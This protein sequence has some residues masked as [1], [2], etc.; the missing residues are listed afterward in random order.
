MLARD[1]W[2]NKFP[3]DKVA[4]EVCP[5]AV[6]ERS[7][8]RWRSKLEKLK[9][10]IEAAKQAAVVEVNGFFNSSFDASL[11]LD[12][13]LPTGGS[14]SNS[15]PGTGGTPGHTVIPRPDTDG[16]PSQTVMPFPRTCWV[17]FK[18]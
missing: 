7:F 8:T 2:P 6:H 9:K 4:R 13:S 18:V 5:V 16:T 3:T 17:S 15:P 10:D 12:S 1:M 14:G 11:T